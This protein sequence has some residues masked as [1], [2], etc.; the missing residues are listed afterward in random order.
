VAVEQSAAG[1]ICVAD[2]IKSTSPAAIE[3]LK[4]MGLDVLMM[5]GDNARAAQAVARQAGIERVLAEVLPQD[6]AAEIEKLQRQGRVVAMAGDGINDAP[7]LARADVG[8]ALG[9]GT[10]IAIEAG[11][12]TLVQGDLQGVAAAIALSR[13]TMRTIRQNLFFAFIY[14]VVL[15]PVAAGALY[16]WFGLL[17]NPML[18]SAAMALSSVSVVSNSLRLRKF[19]FT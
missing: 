9:T 16:P 7:A 1:I 2:T 5:T 11:D 3:R 15:I 8:L 12:I 10:D 14:N 13:Q 18:A 6:K 19:K 4:R 17:L